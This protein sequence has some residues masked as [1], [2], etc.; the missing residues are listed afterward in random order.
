MTKALAR[1]PSQL[2]RIR[3]LFEQWLADKLKTSV[4]SY[5]LDLEA[6]ARFLEMDD[7]AAAFASL[8]KIAEVD[9]GRANAVLTSR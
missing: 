9:H 4:A 7:A 1:R 8:I 2:E 3:D 5:R 6:F